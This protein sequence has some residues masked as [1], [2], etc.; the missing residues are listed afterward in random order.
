MTTDPSL[1]FHLLK[2]AYIEM[3]KQWC[4]LFNYLSPDGFKASGHILKAMI[5]VKNDILILIDKDGD[6]F[7]D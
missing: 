7:D 6:L 2:T 1:D 5:E 3:D 4:N